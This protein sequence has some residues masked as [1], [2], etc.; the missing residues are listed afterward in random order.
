MPRAVLPR[1]FRRR[2]CLVFVRTCI[3]IVSGCCWIKLC[4]CV[5][6]FSAS[7]L[8]AGVS[9]TTISNGK[10]SYLDRKVSKSYVSFKWSL[11]CRS[12]TRVKRWVS[13]PLGGTNGSSLTVSNG[14]RLSPLEFSCQCLEFVTGNAT[15]GWKVIFPFFSASY[16]PSNSQQ[17]INICPEGDEYHWTS[18]F[19]GATICS[20]L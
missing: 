10:A 19:P 12:V 8:I 1:A 3:H 9:S 18:I 16:N 15:L 14:S 5:C 6:I 2:W 11:T 7:P 20:R 13:F 17:G 4:S